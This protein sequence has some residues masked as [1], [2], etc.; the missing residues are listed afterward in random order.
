MRQQVQGGYWDHLIWIK[1]RPPPELNKPDATKELNETVT[2]VSC[3]I[4]SFKDES[5]NDEIIKHSIIALL[6]TLRYSLSFD[7]DVEVMATSNQ[8]K[9]DAKSY[10]K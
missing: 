10:S 5:V 4:S 1:E 6:D 8:S 2:E 3:I 9:C 7:F